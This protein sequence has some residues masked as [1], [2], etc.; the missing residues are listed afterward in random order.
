MK[1]DFLVTLLIL[2]VVC[3]SAS[4]VTAGDA[5]QYRVDVEVACGG[6]WNAL[7]RQILLLKGTLSEQE[8]K[9]YWLAE[10]K[11]QGDDGNPHDPVILTSFVEAVYSGHRD[12]SR[13]QKKCV[14]DV[15]QSDPDGAKIDAWWRDSAGKKWARADVG[16]K[17]KDEITAQ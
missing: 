5:L 17:N 16:A 14:A 11:V 4:P 1:K 8:A 6:M 13:F 15:L 3:F 2:L 12:W 10:Q 9:Q 7:G